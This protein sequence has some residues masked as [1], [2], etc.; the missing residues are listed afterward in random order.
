MFV[1]HATKTLLALFVNEATLLPGFVP[2]APAATVID[3][4]P[5]RLE[6]TLQ[7]HSID[8]TFINAEMA[9]IR[10]HRLAKAANRSVVGIMNEFAHLPSYA[11]GPAGPA[12]WHDVG[13]LSKRQRQWS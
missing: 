10:E 3:R 7:A 2:L 5:E 8:P 4:F 9:A 12:A 1:V 6:V 11:R 13:T